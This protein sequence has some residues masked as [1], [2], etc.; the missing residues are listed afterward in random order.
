[1]VA[2]DD[3]GGHEPDRDRDAY[4]ELRIDARAWL[5]W[6]RAIAAVCAVTLHE[7]A[8]SAPI[9]LFLLGFIVGLFFDRFVL[10][11]LA[12][13]VARLDGRIRHR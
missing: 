2:P 10:W 4:R 1:M 8:S 7:L 3:E 13:L 12:V 6:V 5:W 11:P 9:L